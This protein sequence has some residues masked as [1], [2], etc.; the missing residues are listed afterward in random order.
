MGYWLGF[1]QMGVPQKGRVYNGRFHYNWWSGWYLHLWKAPYQEMTRLAMKNIGLNCNGHRLVLTLCLGKL[2]CKTRV[3][4]FDTFL[5]REMQ[6]ISWDESCIVVYYYML[7]ML[8]TILLFSDIGSWTPDKI[9]LPWH[10]E[11]MSWNFSDIVLGIGSYHSC[12]CFNASTVILNTW[13]C[14]VDLYLQPHGARG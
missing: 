4:G 6:M 3:L 14:C 9:V 2:K 12:S 1:P 5:T 10:V 7:W 8:C 13:C 11:K